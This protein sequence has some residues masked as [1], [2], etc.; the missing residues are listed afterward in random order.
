MA[1]SA[2]RELTGGRKLVVLLL[3]WVF[4]TAFL[5]LYVVFLWP[6]AVRGYPLA[7]GLSVAVAFS[8]ASFALAAVT[9]SLDV[10]AGRYFP[11]SSSGPM[12]VAAPARLGS[13]VRDRSATLVWLR[14]VLLVPLI[15]VFLAEV[16]LHAVP[17]H[18]AAG[19]FTAC[20]APGWCGPPQE[21]RRVDP[22]GAYGY[23]NQPY[24]D[25]FVP[26]QEH[27]GGGFHFRT[28]SLGL[29]R[30]TEVAVPKPPGV[31]RVLVLGDSHLE[32]VNND[33]HYPQ[34]LELL[35]RAR[36]AGERIEVLNAGVGGTGPVHYFQWYR[37]RGAALEPDLVLMTLYLGNDFA[38]IGYDK[39][40]GVPMVGIPAAS[41]EESQWER[42]MEGIGA[43]RP[44]LMANSR[45]L[46]TVRDGV[47]DG[48]LTDPLVSIGLLDRAG[49]GV[50]PSKLQRLVQECHGCWAQYF[51]QAIGWSPANADRV[52]A[53]LETLLV[54]LDHEITAHGGRLVVVALPTKAHVELS[55]ARED[56]E[57]SLQLLDISE[58][59]FKFHQASVLQ[60]ALASSTGAGVPIIDP[61]PAMSEA[62]QSGRLYYRRDWHLNPIGHRVLADLLATELAR[63]HL[64][65]Q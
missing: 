39:L 60:T 55:D 48:P 52:R 11:G 30:D 41:S 23:D 51:G 16:A 36:P 1:A 37:S 35:L 32:F 63:R 18:P 43:I 56:V 57:Q 5:L 50:R 29:H 62:A 44:W 53:S 17:G 9:F 19:E 34:Q 22:S 4:L 47:A 58:D 8:F 3:P 13:V 27:A 21:L 26:L 46:Q 59:Q 33:E 15:S 10:L 54:L 7:V 64:I 65:P 24:V 28:N 25:A 45:I 2:D 49:V 61:L 42:W 14:A 12:R 31:F 20:A 6:R 40:I 38:D